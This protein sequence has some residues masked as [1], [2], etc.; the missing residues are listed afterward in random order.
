M[1]GSVE[2]VAIPLLEGIFFGDDPVWLT[3]PARHL[4]PHMHVFDPKN[5]N[6]AN[7]FCV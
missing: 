4:Q 5:W 7:A 6:K 2:G 3:V 1:R